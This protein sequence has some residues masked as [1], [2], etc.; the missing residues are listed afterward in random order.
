MLILTRRVG[1]AIQIREGDDRIYVTVV[2]IKGAKVR[3]GIEA[4]DDVRIVRTELIEAEI[5]PCVED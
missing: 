5:K 4:P 3:L 2:E 1:E